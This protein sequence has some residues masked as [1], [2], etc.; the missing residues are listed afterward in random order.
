MTDAAV[1]EH[2][3]SHQFTEYYGLN[4]VPPHQIYILKP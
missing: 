2:D 3:D 4:N 1:D